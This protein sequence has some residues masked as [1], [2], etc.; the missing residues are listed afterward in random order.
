MKSANSSPSRQP[1]A[2]ETPYTPR[3]IHATA[4]SRNRIARCLFWL[5][6][7][8]LALTCGLQP[9]DAES[10]PRPLKTLEAP[11]P[12][13]PDPPLSQSGPSL[14]RALSDSNLSVKALNEEELEV[15]RQLI[16]D[17]PNDSTPVG[18]LG[19]VYSKHG[20]NKEAVRYWEESLRIEPNRADTYDAMATVAFTRQEYDRALELARKA[21]GLNPSLTSS[22]RR[23]AESL[24]A[25]G[26]LGEAS[27]ELH[28][29]L[30][31]APRDAEIH[32]MLGSALAQ[33]GDLDA[34]KKSYEA[35]L[36]ID[37]HH[38]QACYQL[39]VVNSRLNLPE[40]AKVYRERFARLRSETRDASQKWVNDYDD[41][42]LIRKQV[43][44]TCDTAARCYRAHQNPARAKELWLRASA[45][46][47][48]YVATLLQLAVVYGQEGQTEEALELCKQ[49]ETIAP[50]DP[51]VH[52]N[53]GVLGA[54]FRQFNVAKAALRKACELAPE[55]ASAA[56]LLSQVLLES[57]GNAAEAVALARKAVDLEPAAE[58]YYVL[59]AAEAR[60]G[61]LAAAVAASRRA[62]DLAPTGQKYRDLLDQLQTNR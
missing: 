53:V 3:A 42:Q 2:R 1:R 44:A 17:Y 9:Y 21:V 18:F 59:G 49:A 27:E 32:Y 47:P 41:L 43:A 36:E 29:A 55:N 58:N 24:I 28:Q 20:L 19:N 25:L 45:L 56:R 5:C 50:Q 39:F 10:P 57:N 35:A 26:R 34:A 12:R 61:N 6:L 16:R 37:P 13:K 54:K 15:A 40:E 7:G 48:K 46:D 11:S 8:S 22:R 30:K 51:M 31:A 62:V 4:T 52:L 23:A 14:D 38:A 33:L 60:R